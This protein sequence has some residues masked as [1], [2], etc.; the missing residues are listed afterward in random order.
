[1][2]ITFHGKFWTGAWRFDVKSRSYLKKLLCKLWPIVVVITREPAIYCEDPDCQ[3][4]LIDMIYKYITISW[5]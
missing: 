2:C 5:H 1:M 3:I 4:N